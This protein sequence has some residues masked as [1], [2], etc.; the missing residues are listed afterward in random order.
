MKEF[1]KMQKL[2]MVVPLSSHELSLPRGPTIPMGCVLKNSDKH[3][4][5]ATTGVSIVDQPSLSLANAEL[6]SA[7]LA[8]IKTRITMDATRSGFNPN[9]YSPPFRYLSLSVP[10]AEIQRNDFLAKGDLSRYFWSFQF[11][12]GC[13]LWF[14]VLLSGVFYA[15]LNIFFGITSAPYFTSAYGAEM[16][17]VLAARGVPAYNMIDDWLVIG[18]TEVHARSQLRVVQQLTESWGFGWAAEKEGVGQRL[19]FLGVLIDTV[20]MTL[21]FDSLSAKSFSVQLRL[22]VS[23]IESGRDLSCSLVSHVAGKL[24]WFAEVV[25]AGRLHIRSWWVY[26]KYGSHIHADA[27]RKLLQDSAWWLR[28]L[29]YWGDESHSPI[30]YEILSASELEAD[31]MSIYVG[32]SDSSGID[33]FGFFHGYLSSTSPLLWYSAKW[34]DGRLPPSS[35]HGELYALYHFLSATQLTSLVLIW[36]FDSSGA[37]FAVNK[38]R[39]AQPHDHDLLAFILDVCDQRRIQIVALWVPRTL[40]TF[41]DHLSHLAHLLDRPDAH[42]TTSDFVD[43]PVATEISHDK[44]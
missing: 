36:I 19:V 29:D 31:P 12:E 34:P 26:H 1:E 17:R 42:G 41:A 3:R 7:N 37:T 16:L 18:R 4:A 8:P 33:G 14:I 30:D 20:S 44:V 35:L 43:P 23:W 10:I 25:Q 11:A 28:L 15:L 5:F 22:Y 40:N 24:N 32:Q 13:R 21:R 27:K 2:G 6:E 39:A 9:A 38:G